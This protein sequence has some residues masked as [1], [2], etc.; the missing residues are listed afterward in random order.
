MAHEN[1][2]SPEWKAAAAYLREV[3]E[4]TSPLDDLTYEARTPDFWRGLEE[5]ADLLDPEPEDPE[6]DDV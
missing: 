6:Q 4:R 5:A 1:A 2:G 3:S